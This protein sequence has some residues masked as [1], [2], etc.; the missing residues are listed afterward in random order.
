MFRIS[1]A[2]ITA[3]IAVLVPPDSSYA[4]DYLDLPAGVIHVA[5]PPGEIKI[6]YMVKNDKPLLRIT[7]G[8]ME[9]IA[10]AVFFGDGK[11]ATEFEAAKDGIHWVS[12]KEKK[13]GKKGFVIDGEMHWEGGSVVVEGDYLTVDKLKQGSV[14]L[15]TPTVKFEFRQS[16][17]ARK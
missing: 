10:H 8:K 9:I 11:A 7:V 4:G 1:A 12:P 13:E 2:L 15:T 6:E 5:L 16:E 17:K 3:L 14:Y